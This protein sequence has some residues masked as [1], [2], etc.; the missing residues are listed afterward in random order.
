MSESLRILAD[1]LTGAFD[2]A[3]PFASPESPVLLSRAGIEAGARLTVSTESR[4]LEPSSAA[5]AVQAQMAEWG[6]P[7]PGT[8]WFKKVDSVLR[9]NPVEECVA[10]IEAGGFARCIFA[11]AFPDMGRV[12]RGGL[13]FTA[14]PDG[15]EVPAPL[16][17]LAAAFACAG[18][19]ASLPGDMAAQIWIVN[20]TS[21]LQLNEVVAACPTRNGILWVG[22]RGLAAALAGA[23]QPRSYPPVSLL[24]AGTTHP[25]TRRQMEMLWAHISVEPQ[26]VDPVPEADNEAETAAGIRLGLEELVSALRRN[27]TVIVIGGDTLSIVLDW[28]KPDSVACIG[29]ALPG[30]PL[31]LLEGGRLDG[32]TLLSK[33]GGFGDDSLLLRL[34]KTGR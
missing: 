6:Q 23:P 1:D 21:Q 12:T 34:I 16:H 22:S 33:S 10:M 2:A 30:L 11:P 4:G 18:L 29:E 31:T 3:A 28:A 17:D 14:T 20:A 7:Q 24:L 13:H 5:A 27:Q 25:T 26:I 8:L 32:M 9:G 19:R 15:E